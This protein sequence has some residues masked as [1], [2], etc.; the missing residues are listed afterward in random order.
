V[1]CV[2]SF[3]TIVPPPSFFFNIIHH[4]IISFLCVSQIYT[5]FFLPIIFP[6]IHCFFYYLFLLATISFSFPPYSFSSPSSFHFN[7][8]QILLSP[9][10]CIIICTNIVIC[11]ITCIIAYT[12]IIVCI[13]IC[14]NIV[15]CIIT[16]TNIVVYIIVYL[17][18]ILS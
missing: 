3:C 5:L 7:V 9:I 13:I 18:L 17:L 4:S 10:V 15:V 8:L 11:I 2:I 14:T 12:N 16:Y 6:S 1:T